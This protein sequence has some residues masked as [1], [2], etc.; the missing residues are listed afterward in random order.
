MKPAPPPRMPLCLCGCRFRAH[1]NPLYSPPAKA[2]ECNLCVK[3]RG[4]PCRV[5]KPSLVLEPAVE[6]EPPE[7]LNPEEG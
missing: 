2:G 5:F 3:K 6:G 1:R 4:R 7:P